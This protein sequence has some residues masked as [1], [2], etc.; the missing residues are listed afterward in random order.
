[1]SSL[2]DSASLIMIPSLVKDGRLDTVKPLGNSII[3]PDATGNNDGTDG[4]T[5]AEGNFTFSRGSNLAATRVDVNG[6]IEKGRENLA[7]Q[8]S[9]ISTQSGSWVV[10]QGGVTTQ[11]A[12]TSPIGTNTASQITANGSNTYS[13]VAQTGIVMGALRYTYSV[14]LKAQSGTPDI[15]LTSYDGVTFHQQDF[16]ITTEWERYSITFTP[17]AG[18]HS[19]YITSQQ[20]VSWYAWGA[21][22][23]LGL[24]ATDYIET[25][26]STAQAGILEDLPRLDYSGGA[27]CPSLLLEPQRTNV[28]TDSEYFKGTDWILQ[29][30]T[31]TNNA[32]ISPEGVQNASLYTS[33]SELYDFVR[34][35]ISFVSGTTYT[36]SVFAKAGTSSLISLGYHSSAFGAGQSAK[37]DLI[38]GTYTLGSANPIVTME[39]YGNDW[40]RCSI[41]ATAT[42]S[43]TRS[44]GFSSAASGAV[45]TMYLYGAQ[46]EQ[47]SYPTSYIPTYGSAVTRDLEYGV[48][49]V[50][51]LLTSNEGTLFIHLNDGANSNGY[52]SGALSVGL[53]NNTGSNFVGWASNSPNPAELRAIY[54]VNGAIYYMGSSTPVNTECKILVRWGNGYASFF[55]NG[56]LFNQQSTANFTGQPLVDFLLPNQFRT[57]NFPIKQTLV[58]PTALT[59]SECIAL[60]T[61]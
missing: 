24:V 35:N 1:M 11:N 45:T 37:F 31:I 49:D 43:T 46:L 5:P 3:H 19:I 40:W 34:Q 16:S 18:T 55:K 21:Q 10:N 41:T 48:S 25:G 8:G 20:G 2:K 26:A 13:G 36:Y 29:D 6:L 51:S 44:T 56:I 30:A 53:Q 38:E 17:A 39:D 28:F 60:T 57:G 47:G 58:F 12:T 50:S 22:F 23:E 27:S 52:G 4:S 61:I 14:Y 59:D 54:K 33:A 9:D 32:A 15:R 7:L 42:A